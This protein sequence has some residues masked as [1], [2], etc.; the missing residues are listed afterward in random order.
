MRNKLPN[1]T[2]SNFEDGW[3][4]ADKTF[5]SL[6]RQDAQ[7]WKSPNR[8]QKPRDGSGKRNPNLLDL[9][10]AGHEPP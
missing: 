7:P 3:Q 2:C 6:R 10:R 4:P 5:P 8:S 1:P 9:G